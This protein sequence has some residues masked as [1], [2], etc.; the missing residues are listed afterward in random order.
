MCTNTNG[1]SNSTQP[2]LACWH[3]IPH[4]IGY[5]SHA[6]MGRTVHCTFMNESKIVAQKIHTKLTVVAYSSK[7]TLPEV[8]MM[9]E[10]SGETFIVPCNVQHSKGDWLSSVEFD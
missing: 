3:R 4:T 10:T 1:Q 6:H 8:A 5:M 2:L 7:D 9:E